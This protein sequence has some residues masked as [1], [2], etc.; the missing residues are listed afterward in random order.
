[1]KTSDPP[2]PVRPPLPAADLARDLATLASEGDRILLSRGPYQ[3]FAFRR[4]EAPA[5]FH[6]LARQRE[7]TFR[8]AGQG[9]GT[10]FDETPEDA[11]YTQLV[12]WDRAAG[13]L[14]GAYRIGFTAEVLPVG[15]IG[16]LYLS[17]M[18]DFDPAFFENTGPALEL[19]RSFVSID[20][21]G[22]RLALAIL[23]QGLG[24]FIRRSPGVRSLFG[25][26]TISASYAPAARDLLVTWLAR[27]RLRP[28]PP[29]VRARVPYPL[30]AALTA[31]IDA[32]P[33]IDS[34]RDRITDPVG[35]PLPIPPLIRHYLPLGATFHAFHREAGFGDAIYCLLDVRLDRLPLTHRK[36]FLGTS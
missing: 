7:I 35:E 2:P 11:R 32:I 6:E 29:H 14:A 17:H 8:A 15:G 26:V 22:D 23:W 9:S 4:P 21:Q 16:G 5:L 3:I 36:R 33:A 25:S 1:M 12:L 30:A 18:F 27:H 10:D 13:R 28:G 20:Y 24:Q 34:L 19:S 31:E